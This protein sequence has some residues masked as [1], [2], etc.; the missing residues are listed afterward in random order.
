MPRLT[1]RACGETPVAPVSRTEYPQVLRA[2]SGTV[3]L[4]TGPGDT[5]RNGS[6]LHSGVV[7]HPSTRPQKAKHSVGYAS[8][9]LSFHDMR[10]HTGEVCVRAFA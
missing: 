3:W 7:L 6:Q 9:R 8:R 10:P 1:S 2:A 4:V 5:K